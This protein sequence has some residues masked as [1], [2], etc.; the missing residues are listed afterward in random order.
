MKVKELIAELN[1]YNPET[2]IGIH[3]MNAD[4][5]CTKII[6]VGEETINEDNESVL[7]WAPDSGKILTIRGE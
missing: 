1:K 3:D 7:E 5:V 4:F 2:E 6:S